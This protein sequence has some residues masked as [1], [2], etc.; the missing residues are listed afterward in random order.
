MSF[1]KNFTAN[2]SLSLEKYFKDYKESI[3][4]PE[5]FWAEKAQSLSWIKNFSKVK[6]CDFSDEVNIQ[7]F[8]GG[9]INVS[10][11]CLDRHLDNK[12]DKIAII[13][14]SDDPNISKKIT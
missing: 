13:W 12:G 10:E 7:W 4:N 9:K 2:S 3:D 5:K 14:E 11:N 6:K 8:L 1:I